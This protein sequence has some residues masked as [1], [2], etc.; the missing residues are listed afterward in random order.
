MDN[1]S[2]RDRFKDAKEKFLL[3]ERERIEEQERMRK[4]TESPISPT[5]N[6][7]HFARRQESMHYPNAK[8]RFERYKKYEGRESE[9]R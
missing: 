3:L 4:N 8:E 1:V 7:R 6:D 2:P 9:E 5:R